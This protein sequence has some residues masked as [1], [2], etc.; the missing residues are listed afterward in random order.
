MKMR[1]QPEQ[2]DMTRAMNRPERL[3]VPRSNV[4]VLFNVEHWQVWLRLVQ[5][6]EPVILMQALL[7][8]PAEREKEPQKDSSDRT[9]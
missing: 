9:F 1:W 5:C 7:R 3:L 6:E 4:D 8:V 2:D